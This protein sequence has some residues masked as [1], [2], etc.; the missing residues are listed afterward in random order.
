MCDAVPCSGAGSLCI[1]HCTI[2]GLLCQWV[3]ARL[4]DQGLWG[5]HTRAWRHDRPHGLPGAPFLFIILCLHELHVAFVLLY[6]VSHNLPV[7]GDG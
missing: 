6:V 5:Q 4:Q 2:W 1:Y 7:R 3:Q